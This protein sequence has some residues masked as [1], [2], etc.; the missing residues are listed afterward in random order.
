MKQ[1]G[2]VKFITK[3]KSLFFPTLKKRVDGYFAEAG[4]SKHANSTMILKTVVLIAAYVLPFVFMLLFQPPFALS[5]LL[6]FVMGLGIGGIGMSV[7]HDA[8]HGAYS[9]NP[10][11]ND[12]LGYSLNLAGGIVQNWKLQHNI[13][14]HT[15]TNVVPMDEDI[16]DRL[17]VRLSPHTTVRGIHRFQWLYAFFFYGILTL[18]WVVLKDFVQYI[19]FKRSGVNTYSKKQNISFLTRIILLKVVYFLVLL[20]LPIGVFGLPAGQVLLGFMLMHFTAGLILTVIF[21]LAHTVEGTSHPLANENGVIE[22]DWAIHQLQTT[23]NFSRRNKW[24]SWYVGGL[25]FQV[26]HHLFPRICHVHYPSIAPIVKQTAEEFG[27]DYLEN[28]TFSDALRSHIS[29]LQ[30]FG[31]LPDLNEAIG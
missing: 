1:K 8:N 10:K 2:K 20:Y 24:L 9:A 12:L 19:S 6:W 23:V 11:V 31:K 21:Q 22:N 5:M 30:R 26:E 17:V 15:Y 25:N 3:D 28:E 13:L 18:Y 14:H 29:T 4:I 7:M 16:Q 27:L